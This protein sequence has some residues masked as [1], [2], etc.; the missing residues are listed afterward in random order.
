VEALV[1]WQHPEH[2]LLGPAEFVGLSEHT[3]LIRE[4]TL[5]VL[6]EALR[7]CAA[8]R[9]EGLEMPVAVNLSAASLADNDLTMDVARL[10]VANG[11]KPSA[12]TLEVTESLVMT[13]PSRAR[14]VLNI[15]RSM[16]VGLSVDDYGTGH[17]SLA[18]LSRL[19]FSELKIDRAFV[20]GLA[21]DPTSAAIVSSTVELGHSLGLEVVAEG[22]E[23]AA[24][25]R[26]LVAAGCDLAQGFHICPP[27]PASHL[28][29]WL[30][31]AGQTAAADVRL[32]A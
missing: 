1:R 28:T 17:S 24:T 11:L 3:G 21:T 29:P 25:L 26:H 23:D 19:P 30:H 10:I 6:E 7:E 14:E 13:D 5:W 20:A 15:L 27:L 8:W 12:L 31:R 22:V 32:A 2:G 4:L 18:Y 16:K 9:A